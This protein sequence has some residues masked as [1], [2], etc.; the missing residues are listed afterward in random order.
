MFSKFCIEKKTEIKST[1]SKLFSKHAFNADKFKNHSI[2][3]FESNI[4]AMGLK[5]CRK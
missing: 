5:F 3:H 1:Y 4:V 2:C